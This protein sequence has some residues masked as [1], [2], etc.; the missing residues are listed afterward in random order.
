LWRLFFSAVHNFEK[1]SERDG[2]SGRDGKTALEVHVSSP[3]SVL[4]HFFVALFLSLL[5]VASIDEI[6][7][8]FP[9]R[10]QFY[11]HVGARNGSSDITWMC[12]AQKDSDSENEVVG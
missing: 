8:A 6:P 1:F 9:R 7:P 3:S 2:I 10:Q 11:P 4:V 12:V 5:V